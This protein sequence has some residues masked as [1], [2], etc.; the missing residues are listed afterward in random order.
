MIK[1]KF[2]LEA[3]LDGKLFNKVTN[4]FDFIPN[5]L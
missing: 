5:S 1:M 2:P 4:R 3:L